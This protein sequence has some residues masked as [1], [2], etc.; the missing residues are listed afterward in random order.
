MN[1][2]LIFVAS[3]L[4]AVTPE[5]KIISSFNSKKE[6]TEARAFIVTHG[7]CQM[8]SFRKPGL[9][10]KDIQLNNETYVIYF[11]IS[12]ENVYLPFK[13]L[14]LIPVFCSSP[15]LPVIPKSVTS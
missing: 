4:T 12:I 8:L 13:L 14:R 1:K 10:V 2:G 7:Q 9:N 15:R 11:L 6:T 5:E 3:L